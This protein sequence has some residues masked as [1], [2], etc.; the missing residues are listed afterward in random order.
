MYV[1]IYDNLKGMAFYNNFAIYALACF[2][3]F[4]Y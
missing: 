4:F 2:V 3:I 1:G